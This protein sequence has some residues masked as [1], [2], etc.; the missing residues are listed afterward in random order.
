MLRLQ[1]PSLIT[2]LL[3]IMLTAS[4][5]LLAPTGYTTMSYLPLLSAPTHPAT[6]SSLLLLMLAHPHSSTSLPRLMILA[7]TPTHFHSLSPHSSS[8]HTVLHTTHPLIFAQLV[9]C[10]ATWA[11]HHPYIPLAAPADPLLPLYVSSR[12]NLS[13][14]TFTHTNL[15]ALIELIVL[16]ADGGLSSVAGAKNPLNPWHKIV[17]ITKSIQS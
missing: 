3:W 14:G 16:S 4:L 2:L 8:S 17:N 7:S 5:L 6:V 15:L 12:T 1:S 9:P 13:I 10:G 11:P